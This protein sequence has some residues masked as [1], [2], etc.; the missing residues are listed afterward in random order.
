MDECCETC[1]L[2]LKIEKL[3]Y[4]K[5]GCAHSHPDGFICLAFADE[6]I[7]CWM[8]GLSQ[9]SDRCE[10]Y[11]KKEKYSWI[12]LGNGE[13]KC[14]KCGDTSA[15]AFKKCNTCGAEMM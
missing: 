5:G 12:V 6:G 15:I 1:K 11:I 7:G 10:C 8:V 3:D 13:Y 2:N 9:K 14:P 4:S